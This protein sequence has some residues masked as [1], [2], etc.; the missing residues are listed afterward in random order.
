[1][2]SSFLYY[3][4]KKQIKAASNNTSFCLN[5]TN[6]LGKKKKEYGELINAKQNS[7]GKR[8]ELQLL[9]LFSSFGLLRLRFLEHL[10][11]GMSAIK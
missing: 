10:C 11:Y 6:P 7:L 2:S 8:R 5:F 3:R 4:E 1:M 9:T